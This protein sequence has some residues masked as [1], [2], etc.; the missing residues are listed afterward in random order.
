VRGLTKA[1][2]E[3]VHFKRSL[4][5]RWQLSVGNRFEYRTL[6]DLAGR[7]PV[8]VRQSARVTVRRLAIQGEEILCVFD[9]FRGTL[10]TALPRNVVSAEQVHDYV[11][12]RRGQ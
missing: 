7:Q 9:Q 12:R 5:D 11:W 3:C 6:C 1:Q 4:W 10:V 2:A 8:V